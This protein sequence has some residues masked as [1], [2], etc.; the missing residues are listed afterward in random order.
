YTVFTGMP[1]SM[2]DHSPPSRTLSSPA[3]TTQLPQFTS[4][5]MPNGL[6]RPILQGTGQA[7]LQQSGAPLLQDPDGSRRTL[8]PSRN[9]FLVR[10]TD[11]EEW[12]EFR[13]TVFCVLVWSSCCCVL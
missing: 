11:A 8:S 13:M 9:A 3:H 5:L 4:L 2:R 1:A 10:G 7:A 12:G 6:P